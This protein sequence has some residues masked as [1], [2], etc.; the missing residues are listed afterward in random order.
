MKTGATSGAE[1]G[2]FG[3]GEAVAGGHEGINLRF[4]G[5]GGRAGGFGGEDLLDQG[6]YRGLLG[7][8]GG[9]MGS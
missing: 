5:N 2:G 4:E 1:L 9:G 7:G 3:G 6:N 8:R